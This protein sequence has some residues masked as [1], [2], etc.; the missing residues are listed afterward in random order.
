MA[1]QC[2]LSIIDAADPD[3]GDDVAI[4]RLLVTALSDSGLEMAQML[5]GRIP[6][7]PTACTVRAARR[8]RPRN[9]RETRRRH[10]RR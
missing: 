4:R 1:E 2:L 5:D 10:K 9:R 3:D 7:L 6:P 8:A